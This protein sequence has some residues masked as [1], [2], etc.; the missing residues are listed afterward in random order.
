MRSVVVKLEGA[1]S[2]PK[3]FLTH[4]EAPSDNDVF[5]LPPSITY[6]SLKEQSR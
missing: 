4:Q 2:D 1:K 5:L 6:F 3:R